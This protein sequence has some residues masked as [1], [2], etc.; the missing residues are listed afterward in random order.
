MK[1]AFLFRLIESYKKQNLILILKNKNIFNISKLII[2]KYRHFEI[3]N[4]L[5]IL[6]IQIF[7]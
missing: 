5:S 4:I 3:K 1:N 7:A 2:L 6:Y